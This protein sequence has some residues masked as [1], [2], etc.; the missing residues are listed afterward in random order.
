MR[1]FYIAANYFYHYILNLNKVEGG[2]WQSL[3]VP[4]A[5]AAGLETPEPPGMI[6]GTSWLSPRSPAGPVGVVVDKWW[7]VASWSLLL[8][9]SFVSQDSLRQ[10]CI[11]QQSW[12][13]NSYPV[14]VE[15]G[16]EVF[17][18]AALIFLECIFVHL[19]TMRSITCCKA[20]WPN[21]I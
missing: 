17:S 8:L 16:G 2:D 12:E 13:M 14:V 11:I 9:A 20:S 21:F 15:R 5:A 3:T 4:R 10:V 1:V 19:K 18:C 7:Q 6:S